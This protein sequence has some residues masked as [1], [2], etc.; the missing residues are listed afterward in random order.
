MPIFQLAIWG[1]KSSCCLVTVSLCVSFICRLFAESSLKQCWALAIHAFLV[2]AIYWYFCL[3]VC[4]FCALC[5][6]IQV[7]SS[8]SHM[9]FATA[10]QRSA[11]SSSSNMH[12][13]SMHMHY[14]DGNLVQ[15]DVKPIT[16]SNDSAIQRWT[17]SKQLI[18]SPSKMLPRTPTGVKTEVWT[19][20]KLFNKSSS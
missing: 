4:T 12:V 20:E 14:D 19:L 8:S 17:P 18:L 3:H 1:V 2:V 15:G 16:E 5:I 13:D 6:Y 9:I 7:E 10:N 11:P